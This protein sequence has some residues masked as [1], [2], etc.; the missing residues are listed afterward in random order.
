MELPDG[1]LRGEGTMEHKE[2]GQKLDLY[3]FSPR[4]L[5]LLLAAAAVGGGQCRSGSPPPP[6]EPQADLRGQI[7]SGASSGWR[8]TGNGVYRLEPINITGNAGRRTAIE[9]PFEWSGLSE[10]RTG[11][12]LVSYECV[13]RFTEPGLAIG[14]WRITAATA[15]WEA[16]CERELMP[17]FGQNNADFYVGKAGCG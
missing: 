8:C 11:G 4:I 14:T 7:A 13:A 6:R 5:L 12:E 10:Q 15:A 2:L 1:V 16:Q 3:R 17:A 9:R